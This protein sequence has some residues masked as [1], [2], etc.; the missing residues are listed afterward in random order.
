MTSHE[1]VVAAIAPLVAKGDYKSA[2]ALVK[3]ALKADP[4]NFFLQYQYAKM[5]GDWADELPAQRQKKYK[6]EAVSILK[7]LMRRLNGKPMLTRFGLSLNFYYQSKD[8]KGMYAFGRRFASTNRQRSLYARGLAATLMADDFRSAGQDRASHVWARR[9][10]VSWKKYDFHN[11]TYYFPFYCYAKALALSGEAAD[12]MA[13]LKKAAKKGKRKID[14][15]EF[16][17]VVQLCRV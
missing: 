14:D 12:A 11:E 6:K 16:A 10:V 2:L 13:Q 15:W 8:W 9:A 7:P 1:A 4:K 5:L 17:D 3:P